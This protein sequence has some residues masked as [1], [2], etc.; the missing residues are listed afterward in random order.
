MISELVPALEHPALQMRVE[1]PHYLRAQEE[2][3]RRMAR[4]IQP[5]CEYPLLYHQG[6]RDRVLMVPPRRTLFSITIGEHFKFQLHGE[7]HSKP[8][9]SISLSTPRNGY[10]ACRLAD[11]R[12]WPYI[13][14][15]CQEY[16]V[17]VGVEWVEV[18]ADKLTPG[19]R[20]IF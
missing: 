6:L 18:H 9:V 14:D 5:L 7:R 3:L 13:E 15:L 2:T 16:M 20:T 17:L 19:E 4:R 1:H 11:D 10:I 12:F 8:H